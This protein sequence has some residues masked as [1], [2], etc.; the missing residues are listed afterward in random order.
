MGLHLGWIP[1][2]PGLRPRDFDRT[3]PAEPVPD[4]AKVA[5]C[6]HRS[7]ELCYIANSVNF[8]VRH[9]VVITVADK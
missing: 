3:A 9:E 7:H 4:P 1:N 8:P 2:E 5:E 6:H